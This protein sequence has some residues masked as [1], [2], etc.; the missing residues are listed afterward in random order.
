M[1]IAMLALF[2]ATVIAAAPALDPTHA[3]LLAMMQRQGV[4]ADAPQDVCTRAAAT[5]QIRP[6]GST[7]GADIALVS[8]G[9][10]NVICGI[11]NCPYL[12]VSFAKGAAHKVLWTDGYSIAIGHETPLPSLRVTSHD[13][14]DTS[15][16]SRFDWQN[17]QYV[18][19]AYL[20]LR[21]ATGET[22]RESIPI[23]FA[24]G[25]S[26]AVLRGTVTHYW[27]ATYELN[28]KSGQ[29]LTISNVSSAMPLW[30]MLDGPDGLPVANHLVAGT[31][32]P[33]PNDGT[34]ELTVNLDS[35][36]DVER[37]QPFQVTVTIH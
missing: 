30:I 24:P 29:Q 26:S 1:E 31:S 18:R 2:L 33:L 19:T 11:V 5:A 14:S 27:D 35:A 28:A 6:L 3:S 9:S 20:R 34:Y 36:Q 4:C 7:Q 32:Y 8:F 15:Y 25:S 16:I 21:I 10:D 37:D 22:R 23:S 12:V 17:G 13:S